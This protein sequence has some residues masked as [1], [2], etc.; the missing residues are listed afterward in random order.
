MAGISSKKSS[1][2]LVAA[3]VVMI[4]IIMAIGGGLLWYFLNGSFKT[5]GFELVTE[6]KT[7]QKEESKTEP[8]SEP[9]ENP[10]EREL[11]FEKLEAS[12]EYEIV[13]E[14]KNGRNAYFVEYLKDNNSQ[15]TWSPERDDEKPWIE[16]SSDK[17][18]KVSKII[19][20]NGYSKK[21]DL[22]YQNERAKKIMIECDGFSKEYT[23]KDLGCGRTQTINLE[24]EVE[25][26]FVKITILS[27]YKGEE[28]N[29][30]VYEDLCITE[31]DIYGF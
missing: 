29:G 2:G 31:V 12:S 1:K 3:V 11:K 6:E 14:E 22:Y 21:E 15:T 4:L 18:Q 20:E 17:K 8:E 30:I 13:T 16:F 23:L 24:D 9:E 27:T 25:T 28:R 19:I 5:E 10:K 26:K 7:E